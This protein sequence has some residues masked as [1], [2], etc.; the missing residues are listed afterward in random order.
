MTGPRTPVPRIV[1]I[2]GPNGAGKTT[3]AEEFLPKEADCPDFVNADL[4]ARGLS[5]FAPEKAAYQ[6]GKLVLRQIAA[7]I[8]A[9]ETFAFE[10]TLSGLGYARLI[11]SWRAA[12]YHVKMIFLSLPSVELALARIR[13]RVA[14]GGHDVPEAVVR[15]RF[16]RGQ[17]NFEQV[18]KPLVNSWI[19]Y[20]NSGPA[21]RL[22]D[23]G[24]NP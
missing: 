14:Q 17:K 10:T 15:R 6:A 2:A 13:G 23:S 21:P 7:R 3:F 18:Y 9:R 8:K 19:V 16:D 1:L 22:L 4:I 24:D 20:D 5:P 12:G 11:P